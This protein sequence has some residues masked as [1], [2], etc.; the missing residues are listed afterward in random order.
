[1]KLRMKVND[2]MDVVKAVDSV[3]IE[4]NNRDMVMHFADGK[5]IVKSQAQNNTMAA[6]IQVNTSAMEEYEKRGV[7]KLGIKV[8]E[9]KDFLKGADG[10]FEMEYNPEVNK[11]YY[12]D[13]KA[14]LETS[15]ID[16]NAIATDSDRFPSA[17]LPIRIKC[18]V[19]DFIG[20]IPRMAKIVDKSAVN[21]EARPN[22]FY[23]H[24][25]GDSSNMVSAKEWSE[26]EDYSI[27]WGHEEILDVDYKVSLCTFAHEFLTNMHQP[28]DDVIIEMGTHTIMLLKYTDMEGMS[29]TYFLA[30]RIPDNDR[31]SSLLGKDSLSKEDA[32]L[33]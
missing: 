25:S 1:M 30:P 19:D 21:F 26:F 31:K 24:M 14:E 29:I 33:V 10:T 2:M 11:L 17:D 32:E 9:L 13:G 3:L 22:H 6:G 12:R 4:V 20:D 15:V 18:D 5:W 8:E 16:P 7:D 27:D 23:T 28:S